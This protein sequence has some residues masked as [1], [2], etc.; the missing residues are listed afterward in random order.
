MDSKTRARGNA[1]DALRLRSSEGSQTAQTSQSAL[2]ESAGAW[3]RSKTEVP[4]GDAID[5]QAGGI[6]D[7]GAGLIFGNRFTV[8]PSVAVPLGFDNAD[9]RFGLAVGFSFGNGR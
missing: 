8:R 5:S 6:L 2:R 7:L 9:P 3:Q 1:L 4:A